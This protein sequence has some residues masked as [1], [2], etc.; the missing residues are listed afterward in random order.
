MPVGTVLPPLG[1]ATNGTRFRIVIDNIP[2][3]VTVFVTLRNIPLPPDPQLTA[4]NNPPARAFLVAG[5]AF[6]GSGGAP[7][8]VPIVPGSTA[9]ADGFQIVALP[10]INGESV[11]VWESVKSDP[12]F[13][14]SLRFGIVIASSAV[15]SAPGATATVLGSLAPITAPTAAHPGPPFPQFVGPVTAPLIG[16]TMTV[17][18]I[19]GPGGPA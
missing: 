1:Q 9:E 4:P 13:A 2:N 5:A 11:A 15:P 18:I 17:S 7:P 12:T 19:G 10:K 6:D 14:E 8:S 16:F 3:N